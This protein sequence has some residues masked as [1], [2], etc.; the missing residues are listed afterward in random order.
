[1]E[2][3][4]DRQVLILAPQ[5]QPYLLS[6]PLASEAK[7][8]WSKELAPVQGA[9]GEEHFHPLPVAQYRFQDRG[10]TWVHKVGDLM[11]NKGFSRILNLVAFIF[12]LWSRQTL[13]LPVTSYWP[14]ACAPELAGSQLPS[15]GNSPQS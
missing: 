15:L 2:G 13:T 4:G 11:E 3:E 5:F 9:E 10:V 6:L 14:G 7:R 1:M 12:C 8:S